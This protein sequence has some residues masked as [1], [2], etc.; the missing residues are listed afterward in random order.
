MNCQ[1]FLGNTKSSCSER[2][3]KVII[4]R[5][6]R[7]FPRKC[8]WETLCL[9]KLRPNSLQAYSKRSLPWKVF[10][11]QLLLSLIYLNI[12][13]SFT[14]INISVMLFPIS[15]ET[16]IHFFDCFCEKNVLLAYDQFYIITCVVRCIHWYRVESI[17]TRLTRHR[18][19][20]YFS[21]LIL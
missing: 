18:G 2:F 8:P 13:N 12:F 7:N 21:G 10:C 15:H 1:L 4:L 19:G 16:I 6:N 9:V 11:G 3:W 14:I 17:Q 5:S 20:G